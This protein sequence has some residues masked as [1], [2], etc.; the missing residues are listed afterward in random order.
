MG[1][2]KANYSTKTPL[3]ISKET[4]RQN[5]IE[6]SAIAKGA[7]RRVGMKETDAN[8][9]VVTGNKTRNIDSLNL[10]KNN[11][12]KIHSSPKIYSS[13]NID[14]VHLLIV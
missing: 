7:A 5:A 3:S 11:I 13:S 10:T 8:R 4:I 9:H 14:S 12:L 6:R 1:T 2:N